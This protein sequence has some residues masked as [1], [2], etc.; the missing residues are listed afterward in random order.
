[1]TD[2]Q[3]APKRTLLV[4]LWGFLTLV[5][6]I[7]TPPH[8]TFSARVLLFQP[9]W[10][11][12]MYLGEA[13]WVQDLFLL[14]IVHA[15]YNYFTGVWRLPT[16][17]DLKGIDLNDQ[18]LRL[19]IE[20]FSLLGGCGV[21]A[22]GIVHRGNKLEPSSPPDRNSSRR[23]DEQLLPPLLIPSRTTHSRMFPK[24]HAF[25]YSYL[26]VGI[27][28]G[29]RGRISNALSVDT[30]ERS[31]FHVSSS[32]YLARR[33][34]NLGLA[35]KL[36]QYL[37]TQG[38][39]D[40][41][42]SFAYLVTAPRL[43][44]YSFNPVSF[45]YLYDADIKLKYMI[46]EVNNTF[47]ERRMYLLTAKSPKDAAADL[48]PHLSEGPDMSSKTMVFSETFEKD[49][50]VSPF[51]S[52]KG[53]Y[54]LRAI[55]PLASYE[56]TGQVKIDNT[57]IL[58]S[59]KESAKLVARV[60]SEGG[61]REATHISQLDLARFILSW[62]WVGL[63]TFPRIVWQAQKLF[64]RRKLHV[65]YRPEVTETSIGRTY[66][67]DER[68]LESFFRTFLEHV[69]NH[70]KQPLRLIYEPAHTEQEIVMYSS[71]FTFEEDHGR[72][73]TLKVTSPAFYS[74]FVHYAHAKE[75]FDRECL[76]TDE[77]DRTIVINNANL[78][79][80][81]L[82]AVGS[83]S[84]QVNSKLGSIEQVKWT[85]LRRLRCPPPEPSH[86]SRHYPDPEYNVIDIRTFGDA[87]LDKF[88][89]SHSQDANAYLRIVTKLF[90]SDRFA[91]GIPVLIT[92]VDWLLRAALLLVTM[93]YA[94]HS[95]AL[96]ILRPR[97]WVVGDVQSVAV[98]LILAN[99]VHIWSFVKG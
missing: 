64:F 8:R 38:V 24:K 19:Y 35:E 40:R 18:V 51:N 49:F 95:D 71:A 1:M 57:V 55:D 82:H 69:V 39:T 61:S 88:V 60:Y 3:N 90:L 4:L 58:R 6:S 10:G 37:H 70:A 76:A 25:S 91:F 20:I 86:H 36:K 66:T 15:T 94:N 92:G 45:W 13:T 75:A 65:W 2:N 47:D 73:L 54:S 12:R 31:W 85:C 48:Y 42:Y 5:W 21:L 98:M 97:K 59:S 11:I 80:I 89:M 14:L 67:S 77:K 53:S 84:G 26:F 27:P 52:R 46:L 62:W 43:F 74:R 63:A 78:L 83:I 50:H 29:L 33:Y 44:G 99:A 72:T 32:D 23:I 30:Q 81:F 56:E 7:F 9:L 16:I 68:H 17:S 22:G 87:E 79:P 34:D 93:V 41:N 28:V 96:D